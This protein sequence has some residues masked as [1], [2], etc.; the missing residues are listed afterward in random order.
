MIYKRILEIWQIR[1]LHSLLFLAIYE[2]IYEPYI[3]KAILYSIRFNFS[4]PAKGDSCV[5]PFL[6]YDVTAYG[7]ITYMENWEVNFFFLLGEAIQAF[8]IYYQS[9]LYFLKF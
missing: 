8:T 4:G 6:Y 3:V 2:R 5:F 1:I 7:C 9:E